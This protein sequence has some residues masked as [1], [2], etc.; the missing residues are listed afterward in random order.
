MYQYAIYNGGITREQFL[1][2]EMKI[3]AGLISK[4]FSKEEALKKIIEE[5][6][7]QFPTERTIKIVAQGCFRRL[8]ALENES[9]VQELATSGAELGKQINL[10]AMMRYNLIVWDFMVTLIGEK[11]RTQDF[12]FSIKDM[13]VFLNRLREQVDGMNSW[14]DSTMQKIRQV[15]LKILV[16]CGYLENTKST[17]LLTVTLFPEVENAIRANG[18]QVA[19]SAF[20]FFE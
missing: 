13:N 17:E 1:F 3:T 10:Y 14:S 2:Y 11:Y 20:N 7:Y 9:L 15:L 18:E 8:D 16:E 4:G 6:L 5:N 19:F 12:S